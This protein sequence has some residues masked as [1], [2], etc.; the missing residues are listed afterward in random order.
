MR[1]SQCR[2]AGGVPL[3][4]HTM[5]IHK[6]SPPGFAARLALAADS[7][8]LLPNVNDVW[9]QSFDHRIPAFAAV[10]NHW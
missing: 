2:P 5:H 3:A 10:L 7:R 8:A 9:V 6:A 4:M 1:L